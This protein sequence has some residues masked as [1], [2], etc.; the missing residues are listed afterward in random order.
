MLAMSVIKPHPTVKTMDK[1]LNM[2]GT[3]LT[4]PAR[5]VLI[6]LGILSKLIPVIH[7]LATFAQRQNYFQ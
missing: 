6:V 7:I 4:G 3:F 2:F 1:Y 5:E